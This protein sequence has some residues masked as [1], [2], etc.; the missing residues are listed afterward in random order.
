LEGVGSAGWPALTGL[1]TAFTNKCKK[2]GMT[3]P[4][5]PSQILPTPMLPPIGQDPMR[6][7]AIQIVEQ[8][9]EKFGKPESISIIV[10]LLSRTDDFIYPAIKRFTCVRLGV[11]T[12][13]MLLEK[14]LRDAKKQDQYLSNIALKVN[15]KLGGINHS[16]DPSAMKWLQ[17]KKTMMIGI[18]V[19]HPG[20]NSAKGTPSIAGVV[21]SIDK[22]FVQFPASLRLQTSK[23]EEVRAAL[24]PRLIGS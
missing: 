17:D 10:V 15:T 16:L 22:E 3:M 12:Q 13:C 7:R 1:L 11:R 9:I 21:G 19:T 8:T 2:S 5:G 14:A 20:P 18:D 4:P 23:K 24:H 6:N